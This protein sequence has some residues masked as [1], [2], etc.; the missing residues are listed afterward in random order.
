LSGPLELKITRVVDDHKSAPDLI[1]FTPATVDS[2]VATITVISGTLTELY[3]DIIDNIIDEHEIVGLYANDDID[4]LI[5]SENGSYPISGT[6]SFI[7]L[8]LQIRAKLQ[9]KLNDGALT[10]GNFSPKFVGSETASYFVSAPPSLNTISA[11]GDRQI[12]MLTQL[13]AATPISV[14]FLVTQEVG[15]AKEYL[16][17]FNVVGGG[18]QSD[19]DATLSGV[20]GSAATGWKFVYADGGSVLTAPLGALSTGKVN[21]LAILSTDRGTDIQ[22][23]EIDFS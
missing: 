5:K 13:N 8:S 9:Y 16:L 20:V 4:P 11:G 15:N 6:G 19:P 18:I 22:V 14:V 21:V 23:S 12:H 7:A 10:L 3:A 17:K 1:T 2:S